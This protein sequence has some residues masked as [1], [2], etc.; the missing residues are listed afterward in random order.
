[1]TNTSEILI[2][3]LTELME[4]AGI[5]SDQLAEMSGLSARGV[6]FILNDERC[7][8]VDSLDKLAAAFCM[9][10]S[11]LISP[12]LFVNK[13]LE[14][15]TVYKPSTMIG[16]VRTI[17]KTLFKNKKG[18]VNV[19]AA[20]RATGLSRQAIMDWLTKDNTGIKSD[21]LRTLSDLYGCS[22]D[23]VLTGNCPN[24][25]DPYE[26]PDE[27]KS[28]IDQE[29]LEKSEKILSDLGVIP[30]RSYQA[31]YLNQFGFIESELCETSLPTEQKIIDVLIASRLVTQDKIDQ[32][33]QLL[34]D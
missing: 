33:R 21:N 8:T 30:S 11:D 17:L 14:I 4:T 6:R 19:S 23:W 29:K 12:T 13:S 2:K 3:N 24:L 15:E 1:M 34:T 25:D 9:P 32:I 20:S 27:H 18:G 28:P 7:P 31:D 10:A 26:L 22:V 16:R 5:N